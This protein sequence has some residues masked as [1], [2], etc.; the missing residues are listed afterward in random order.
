MSHEHSMYDTN[1]RFV[2]DTVTKVVTIPETSKPVLTQ[3]DHNSE[4]ITFE[5]PR[6]VEGHDFAKSDKVEVHYNNIDAGGRQTSK[7]LYEAEDLR[8]DPNDD[9]KV[10]FTWIVSQMAT[11]YAGSLH[12]VVAFSCVTDGGLNYRWNTKINSGLTVSNGIYNGEIVESVYADVLE[13][14]KLDLF[15][16]G[17]TEES[18]MITLAESQRQAI[19]D[20]G[21]ETLKTIPTS[22][23]DMYAK[24]D[25]IG[26]IVESVVKTSNLYKVNEFDENGYYTHDTGVFSSDMTGY[27]STGYISVKEN[28]RY[29]QSSSGYVTFWN[30][31]KEFIGGQNGGRTFVTPSGCSYINCAL[32]KSIKYTYFVTEFGDVNFK[33]L[34]SGVDRLTDYFSFETNNMYDSRLVGE[35]CYDLNGEY[36]YVDDYGSFTIP[37]N[38]NEKYTKNWSGYVAYFDYQNNWIRTDVVNS[39]NTFTVP[40]NAVKMNVAVQHSTA[41]FWLLPEGENGYRKLSS[42]FLPN[43]LSGLRYGALGDSITYGLEANTCY[44]TILS[45]AESITFL[46]YGI[47]GNRIADSADETNN[48]MHVRYLDMSDDLDIITVFGGTNDCASQ[49]PIGTNSDETGATFKGALNILTRGLLRKYVG[50]RIG[51]ITPIQRNSDERPIKLVEYVNAIKEICSLRGIPVLDL[52]NTSTITCVDDDNANGLLV[53]GL[54]PSDEGH[55]VIARKVSSF[56]KTL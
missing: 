41:D 47:S 28:I 6:F 1:R 40:S 38:G 42:E 21:V 20:T 9:R 52:Y 48:P 4:Y 46:N 5:C 7:G 15:G 29:Y 12:F 54:H 51:F 19:I 34:D 44:G 35:G 50:K 23:S 36:A 33:M 18:R 26:T 17:D 32:L 11:A 43:T 14:W 53:D 39:G 31:N 49:T 55:A 27:G 10:I 24:L 56:I 8:V 3:Y 30:N 13:M 2:I 16:I 22:Y 37:V 25:D 45:E